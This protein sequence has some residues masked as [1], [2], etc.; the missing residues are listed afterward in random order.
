MTDF[1]I[2]ICIV[3][4]GPRGLS[5][6]ERI[7][8]NAGERTVMVHL[9]DPY[10][11][12]AG[13]VWRTDQSRHL[14]MNT[15]AS[16]ITMFTDETVRMSGPVVPGPSLETW[17][18]RVAAAGQADG[19]DG[20]DGWIRE[21]ARGIGPNTYPTRA[22]YGQYLRWVFDRVVRDAPP[23]VLVCAHARQVVE[24]SDDGPEG[25]QRVLLDDGTA[26]ADV[27]A[28]VL[29]QGH[30]PSAPTGEESTL[31][32][33][34]REFGLR[35]LAPTNPA[36][37]DLR[38]V[39]P[40]EPVLLRG[41]GLCFFDYVNLL[42]AGRGGRFERPDGALRYLPS[43]QEPRLYA[44]SR[45]G[46]PYHARGENEKGAFGRHEPRVLNPAVIDRLRAEG[47]VAGGLDF[48]RDI[49]PLI[50]K[51]VELVYYSTLLVQ[52]GSKTA[53]EEFAEAYLPAPWGSPQERAVLDRAGI[54]P[55]ARWSWPAVTDPTGG[56]VFADPAEFQRWLTDYLR[57]DIA[58]A[59][60]GNVTSPLK[61]ALD[62]LR[63]L[64]NEVRLLVD[65]GGLTGRS[66]RD[67]L[68]GWFTP[69][70]AFLSIGPPVRRSEETLALIEAGILRIVGPN[71]R[72]VVDRDAQRFEV[73]SPAVQGSRVRAETLIEARLGEPDVRHTTDPLLRRML[74][75]D[76]A[77]PYR[78]A[79]PRHGHHE[80]AGLTVAP[81]T[82]QVV[83]AAGR[84]HPRRFAFG[85]PT[86]AV[87]WVTAA[88]IRPG[89]SSVTLA[90][91]DAIARLALRTPGGAH[92]AAPA[93]QLSA[94]GTKGTA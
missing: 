18:R 76:Q 64:R 73:S 31:R 41:L 17:A 46:V 20:V 22:F 61:A 34:A 26:I 72:V 36:D 40:G 37:A 70:N 29:A 48:R 51:E 93:P 3:G 92:A 85:V 15:V 49:W 12:G 59:R 50:A 65:H 4:A 81:R 39:R 25:T 5:V 90:D 44:G 1:P 60:R 28:V 45:R 82:F 91:A 35:Y 69:M 79:D 74:S 11:P 9:I 42:T 10:P 84:P 30:V 67:D 80:T 21:E 38:R 62:V 78:L 58:E 7:C 56:R 68:Y 27:D 71:M 32:T 19:V 77:R 89:V 16:Q 75:T 57:H 2:R 55:P 88:G 87:H 63:D 24:L 14:L 33:F 47:A 6:L 8:A 23:G 53:A 83:N 52:R 94:S 13:K 86:E 66:H 54:Q 43:G